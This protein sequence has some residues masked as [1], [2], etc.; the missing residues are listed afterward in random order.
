MPAPYQ[1]L[2]G[3]GPDAAARFTPV[4]PTFTAATPH[5][6]PMPAA[7]PPTPATASLTA[8]SKEGV[9]PAT[10]FGLNAAA[11]D[12]LLLDTTG[13]GLLQS[14]PLRVFRY[15]GGSTSDAFHW[16][17]TTITPNLPPNQQ[18]YVNPNDTFD[19]LMTTLVQ[20]LGGQALVTVNYGSNAAGTGGGDPTEAANWVAYAKSKN[21]GVKYWEIGNEVYGS[22][23]GMT[24]EVN[25]HATKTPT[26]YGQDVATYISAMKAQD[27]TIKCGVV[28]CAPGSFPDGVAPDWNS[29]VLAACGTVIDFVIVHWYTTQ[30]PGSESDA[31][32]LGQPDSIGTPTTGLMAKI[33]AVITAGCGANAPN[34]GIWLTE[35]NSAPYNVGKQTIH[36]VNGLFA[37]DALMTFLENGAA[38]VCWWAYHNGISDSASRS[39]VARTL[40]GADNRGV[41][42]D[43]GLLSNGNGSNTYK[44]IVEPGANTPYPTYYALQA[45]TA[46]CTVGDTMVAAS[47]GIPN[48]VCHQT[49]RADGSTGVLLINRDPSLTYQVALTASGVTLGARYSGVLYG[50]Q[51]FRNTPIQG[52]TATGVTVPPLS[53]V[54]VTAR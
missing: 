21:Y 44:E 14:L 9:I 47:T 20:P 31:I 33:K 11:F 32:L 4:T 5:F 15:P 43:Y 10:A 26:Q 30:N 8:T 1:S 7:V 28:L 27:S 3:Y 35:V 51:Q 23:Y 19:S 52:A 29:S 37:A 40:A 25:L 50:G 41:Y 49:R 24:Y 46:F 34:V 42:G 48:L 38:N 53:L 12:G 2:A 17:T 18:G 45:L 22:M 16:Q 6:Q 13:R 36:H 39:P 54:A